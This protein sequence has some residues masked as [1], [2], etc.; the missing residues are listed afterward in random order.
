M[1]TLIAMS[2]R[3]LA[4]FKASSCGD[5]VPYATKALVFLFLGLSFLQTVIAKTRTRPFGHS[6][7]VRAGTTNQT[8]YKTISSAVAALPNDYSFQSIFIYP[9]TYN[10]QVYITRPGPLKVRR[11]NHAPFTSLT[12]KHERFTDTQPTQ[13]RM[14][15]I[16]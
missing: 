9:G 13:R 16:R 14:R 6:L 3:G 15:P 11:M 5:G 4:S 2:P 12:V 1:L 7:V 10:E 8:E